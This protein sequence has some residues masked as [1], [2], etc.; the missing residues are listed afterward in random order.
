MIPTCASIPTLS[1]HEASRKEGYEIK[2]EIL[3]AKI[4]D[5]V[6][7]EGVLD[8]HIKEI[9]D[10]MEKDGFQSRPIAVSRLDS[11][12]PKWKE[13]LLIHDGHHRTAALNALGCTRVMVSIFDFS[14]PRIKVSDYNDTSIPISK[15]TV[16]EQA[17]S[18]VE[19]TPRF[20]KHFIESNGKLH[21]FH[22]NPILEP[23]IRVN[24]SELK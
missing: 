1:Q 7:H 24:L 23:E 13:N 12:G 11:L 22:D 16:I 15:E 10:W 21:P 18:G 17:T 19:L 8:W 6:P 2:H 5:L 14:D 4:S 9:R 3:K 20:D